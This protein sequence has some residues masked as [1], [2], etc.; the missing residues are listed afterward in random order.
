MPDTVLRVVADSSPHPIAIVGADG[1]LL[2][3]NRA[4]RILVDEDAL[5]D[6]VGHRWVAPQRRMIVPTR[7]GGAVALEAISPDDAHG[8]WILRGEDPVFRHGL[9]EEAVAFLPEPAPDLPRLELE[10]AHAARHAMELDRSVALLLL[11]PL[12]IDRIADEEGPAAVQAALAWLDALLCRHVRAV[13]QML[14]EDDGVRAIIAVVNG[15]AGA[16]M[17]A[18]RLCGVLARPA[19]VEDSGRVLDVRIGLAHSHEPQPDRLALA[20]RDAL[21]E[22]TRSK[23]PFVALAADVAA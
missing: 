6:A 3:A 17:L 9:A 22:A 1:A 7:I 23:R 10:L 8:S 11:Q 16:E 15:A 19:P 21:Q 12:D 20:A 18:T 5:E 2:L 14:V 4:L 13:D